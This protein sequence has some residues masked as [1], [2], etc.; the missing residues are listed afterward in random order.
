MANKYETYFSKQAN[1]E[2]PVFKSISFQKG[3]GFGLG[4]IMKKLFRFIIPIIKTHAVP[5]LKSVGATTLKGVNNFGMDA[6][7]GV[8][9]RESAQNRFNQSLDELTEKANIKTGQGLTSSSS[10]GSKIN[11]PYN[12][13]K[14]KIIKNLSKNKY[15]MKNSTSTTTN[16]KQKKTSKKHK[17]INK[18]IFS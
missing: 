3:Y 10:I 6:L 1:Q 11:T 14:R 15:L 5:I 17:I 12:N 4:S 7:S 2:Y 9:L 13:R 18:D 8:P 16:K